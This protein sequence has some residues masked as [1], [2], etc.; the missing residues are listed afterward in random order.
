LVFSLGLND[1]PRRYFI[2]AAKRYD[3]SNR[4]TLDVK[5]RVLEFSHF[6]KFRGQM[7]RIAST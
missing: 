1:P 4:G 2:R 3:A 5:W 6:A 7:P